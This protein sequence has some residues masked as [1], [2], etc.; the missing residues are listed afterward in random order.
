[1]RKLLPAILALSARMAAQSCASCYTTAA[2]AGPRTVHAL[3][4]GILL[5][6]V[7]SLLLFGALVAIALRWRSQQQQSIA[8]AAGPYREPTSAQC[9][10]TV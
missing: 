4:N 6:L 7:P 5:L 9:G 10:E 2:A 8:A 1:M 3:R